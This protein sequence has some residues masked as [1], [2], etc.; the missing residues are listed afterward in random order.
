MIARWITDDFPCRF[1]L[2]FNISWREMPFS[3][4]SISFNDGTWGI[5][6][7]HGVETVDSFEVYIW[8]KLG[9]VLI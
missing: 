3:D 4:T 1:L 2:A 9:W 7:F 8:G 5:G 6:M